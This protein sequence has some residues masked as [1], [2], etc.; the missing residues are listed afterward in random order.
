MGLTSFGTVSG[1]LIVYNFLFAFVNLSFETSSTRRTFGSKSLVILNEEYWTVFSAKLLLFTILSIALLFLKL[2][3]FFPLEIFKIYTIIGLFGAVL[4]QEYI[5]I[6]HDKVYF[7]SLIKFSVRIGSLLFLLVF[8][9]KPEHIGNYLL[10]VNLALLIQAVTIF[11]VSCYM[12]DLKLEFRFYSALQLVRRNLFL[13]LHEIVPLLSNNGI[14]VILVLVLSPFMVGIYSISRIVIDLYIQILVLMSRYLAPDFVS[15]KIT[16]K[17]INSQFMKFGIFPT[18]FFFFFQIW[19][20]MICGI[21]FIESLS[22]S[23]VLLLGVY[24]SYL[25]LM[26]GQNGLIVMNYDRIVFRD[27]LIST[28]IGLLITGLLIGKFEVMGVFIS[29]SMSRLIL[30]LSNYYNY[31]VRLPK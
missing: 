7:L 31:N 22:Y 16:L 29:L 18:I 15:G 1:T 27:V 4:I 17:E 25:Y 6:Y 23:F 10:I 2:P 3:A 13:Y 9:R 24:G 5:F 11:L 14:G 8:V 21:S 19:Y 26:F 20:S 12:F 30:G 28:L